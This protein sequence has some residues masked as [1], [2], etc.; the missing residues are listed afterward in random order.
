MDEKTGYDFSVVH[1]YSNAFSILIITHPVEIRQG[2]CHKTHEDTCI[3]A[4]SWV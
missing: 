2:K 4:A 3:P 1:V